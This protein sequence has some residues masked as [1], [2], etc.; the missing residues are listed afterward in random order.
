MTQ[1]TLPYRIFPLGDAAFS[2]EFQNESLVEA[3]KYVHFFEHYFSKNPFPYLRSLV[4]AYRTLTFHID[5]RELVF[6]NSRLSE[7]INQ[8]QELLVAQPSYL[9]SEGM[10]HRIPVR[11]DTQVAPDL[12]WALSQ[13]GLSLAEFINVHST[14]IY[15]V[16][17][18]GFLPGFGYLG[19]VDPVIQLPRKPVPQPVKAGS[20]G[21]AGNQTGVYPGDSPGGWQIIGHTDFP[22][23]KNGIPSLKAGDSVQFYAIES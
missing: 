5:L 7:V 9:P 12:A 4:P 16:F 10:L 14:P 6:S 1:P 17:M 21:I 11:Y 2:I 8:V 15:R 22:F 19:E 13:T 3:N 20:V 23:I 18:L